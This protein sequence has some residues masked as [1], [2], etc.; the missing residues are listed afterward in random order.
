MAKRINRQ[1]LQHDKGAILSLM[2]MLVLLISMTSMVLM[3]I[4]QQA[5]LRTVKDTSQIAARFAADAGIERTLYYMNERLEAGIWSDGDV[6][7][8]NSENLTGGN[9][10]YTVT[11]TGDLDSG[12][13]LTS[14][15]KSGNQTKTVRVT[16]ELTNPF[17]DNFAVLTKYSLSMKNS[18]SVQG[19]NSAD[20]SEKDIPARIGKTDPS[21]GMIDIKNGATV[22]GDVVLPLEGDTDDHLGY[23][24]RSDIAGGI[25]QSP[26]ENDMPVIG[27]PKGLWKKG[28][29]SG[30][31][32][33]LNS[34]DSGQYNRISISNNGTL[35]VNGD[36]T[37]YVTGDIELK[38]SAEVIVNNGSSLNLYID[39]DIEAKNSTGITNES[40]VPS[41]VKIYGTGTDQQF[42]MKN[43]SELYGVVY[44]PNVDMLLHNG[45]DAYGAFIVESFEMKNSGSVYY[46]K[47]LQETDIDD[48]GA[49]FSIVRW[50]EI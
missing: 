45:A 7:T 30:S 28:I 16:L 20:L 9:A 32:I 48:E 29:I 42:E 50:E 43:S 12:Y 8:F 19:Y 1:R 35:T 4:G 33:T 21:K 13:I 46:D 41:N 23:K 22:D 39:G 27:V 25:L 36:L 44:G 31:N 37:L 47:A 18:S 24:N 26:M 34:S 38:N 3:R 14:V 17:A 15:G 40:K 11:F 2:V 6:P 5:R 10:E 49:R